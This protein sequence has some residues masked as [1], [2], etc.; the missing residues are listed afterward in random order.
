MHG[1][2]LATETYCTL[3]E[4]NQG[5]DGDSEFSSISFL[6]GNDFFLSKIFVTNLQFDQM[7][8]YLPGFHVFEINGGGRRNFFFQKDISTNLQVC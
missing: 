8:F 2:Q 3:Q 4:Q 7:G 5:E 6:R 1:V